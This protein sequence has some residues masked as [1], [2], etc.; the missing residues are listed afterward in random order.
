MIKTKIWDQIKQE[1]TMSESIWGST[2]EDDLLASDT[3]VGGDHYTKL[4]IQPMTYSMA[5]NLNALQ[6]TALKYITRYQ[7]KGTPLQDLAKARHCIDMMVE[8]WMDR[9]G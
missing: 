1:P 3:Q 7:D 6:H 9:D 5:N 8:D 2:E 4:E